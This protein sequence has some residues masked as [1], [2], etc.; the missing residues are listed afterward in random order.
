MWLCPTAIGPYYKYRRVSEPVKNNPRLNAHVGNL[1]HTSL[2]LPRQRTNL[3]R[4]MGLRAHIDNSVEAW[5]DAA[6]RHK[7]RQDFVYQRTIDT[8][9]NVLECK[10]AANT[11][12]ATISS[13]YEPLIKRDPHSSPVG[14][15]WAILCDAVRTLG[16]NNDLT[17]RL[18]DLLI[19]ISELPDVTDDHGNP[20]F[21]EW[22]SRG[23]YWRILP[24]FGWIFK[25]HAMGKSTICSCA[26][27]MS[28]RPL[29]ANQLYEQTSTT[30]RRWKTTGIVRPYL[31]S[32]L[33]P[34]PPSTSIGVR[35]R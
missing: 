7:Y 34:S 17:Q 15:V 23:G 21:A 32:T 35:T 29:T 33:L 13:L 9:Q 16:G 12:A 10:T 26:Q 3:E 4:V 31:C 20:I 22:Q 14:P 6:R 18:V 28:A 8:F 24:G 5:A 25:E 2:Q 11:A 27:S 30:K 19:S 1:I